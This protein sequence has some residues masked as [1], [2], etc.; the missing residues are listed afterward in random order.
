MLTLSRVIGAGRGK[1]TQKKPGIATINKVFIVYL[2]VLMVGLSVI[3]VLDQNGYYLKNRDT[4]LL[5]LLLLLFSLLAWGGVNIYR[6]IRG[7]SAKMIAGIAMGILMFVLLTMTFT[8]VGQFARLLYPAPY[9]VIR[10]EKSGNVAAVL[11]GIDSGIESETAF[12]ETQ[13]RMDVR[14][15]AITDEPFNEETGYP[16]EA[17]GYYI[18]A[19]PQKWN[20][21]YEANADVEGRIFIGYAS[22]AQL[23]YEWQDDATLRLYLENPEPGD[24]GEIILHF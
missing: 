10:S 15:E 23:L 20:F 17:Y 18:E 19:Y 16:I 1:S 4:G 11:R 2:A 8:Y 5:G 6:R 13:A 21:F 22:Q 3:N 7:R 24:S 12:E 14:Y 9:S